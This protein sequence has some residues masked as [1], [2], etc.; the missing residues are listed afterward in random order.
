MH[1][2]SDLLVGAKDLLKELYVAIKVIV[3]F[4]RGKSRRN[5]LE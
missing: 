3:N 1:R 5:A 4:R 2:S